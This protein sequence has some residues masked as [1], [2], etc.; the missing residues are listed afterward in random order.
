M[1]IQKECLNCLNQFLVEKKEVNR[2][3]GKF[4]SK[5]CVH[6]FRRGKPKKIKILNISCRLCS[7]MVY[8]SPC[9]IR[10]SRNGVFFCSRI[11]KDI[12]QR[13]E[14][15]IKEI[16]PKHYGTGSHT[17]S[18]IAKRNFELKCSKCTI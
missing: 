17:F 4:C 18:S 16:H 11:C 2:G 1:K 10:R 3:H 8:K 13:I 6:S 9:N 5:E 15:N 7:K 14:N 12:G